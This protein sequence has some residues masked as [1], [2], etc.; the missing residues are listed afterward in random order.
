MVVYGVYKFSEIFPK[1]FAYL[2][3]YVPKRHKSFV[4]KE[5]PDPKVVIVDYLREFLFFKQKYVGAS[6]DGLTKKITLA[7]FPLFKKFST[8]N[9]LNKFNLKKQKDLIKIYKYIDSIPKL[10]RIVIHEYEHCLQFSRGIFRKRLLPFIERYKSK[11]S[12][13]NVTKELL[14]IFSKEG[15][16]K[17][18]LE[19]YNLRPEEVEA[20]LAEWIYLKFKSYGT[21]TISCLDFVFNTTF[22]KA[23]SDLMS[24]NEVIEELNVSKSRYKKRLKKLKTRKIILETYLELYPKINAEA[25]LIAKSIKEESVL[26]ET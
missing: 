9:F 6:Y 15:L 5:L 14:R 24:I 11:K 21:E 25:E 23:K 10:R 22:K 18:A 7:L 4:G 16:V 3:K 17:T 20:R 12:I 2:K 8:T 26:S 1:T 13:K 19:Q